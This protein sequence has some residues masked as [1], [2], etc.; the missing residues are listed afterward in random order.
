MSDGGEVDPMRDLGLVED[1]EFVCEPQGIVTP[2]NTARDLCEHFIPN[3]G[4]LFDLVERYDA[5]TTLVL[6]NSG[7]DNGTL[8]YM[9]PFLKA[10]GATDYTV[11]RFFSENIPYNGSAGSAMEYLENLMPVFMDSMVYEHA[12]D[13]ICESTGVPLDVCG[14]TPM[15]LDT[16]S[17]APVEARE[18][19][20][21]AAD[22][23]K[24]RMPK[25]EY[26]E[27]TPLELD[28]DEVRLVNVLDGVFHDRFKTYAAYELIENTAA[29]GLSEKAYALLDIRKSTQ[30][31]LDGIMYAG[32]ESTDFQALDLV[33]E[34]G[35]LAL[36]FNGTEAAVHG[37]SVAL[38]DDDCTSLA[39]IGSV[40]FDTGVQ[41]VIDL[42]DNWN[43]SYLSTASVPDPNIR[44][45]L[46]AMHP[47]KLPE[48]YVLNEDNVHQVATRS[49]KYRRK[50]MK[51]A[52]LRAAKPASA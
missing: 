27:G 46:L 21:I 9:A 50:L 12:A 42:A 7:A 24:L 38:I 51:Q 39:F 34:S 15:E 14:S 40:F 2:A 30:V 22:I 11:S 1:K 28:R 43:R 19:R 25:D 18:I 3:G 4:K 31:D 49:D 10:Y 6:N 44:D 48:L 5:I 36:S 47:K 41:G 52:K 33:A 45:H 29:V 26:E 13:V 16:C 32:S 20:R 23:V 35:G 8:R 37:S 17:M